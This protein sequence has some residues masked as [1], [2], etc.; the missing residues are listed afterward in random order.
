MWS[1]AYVKKSILSQEIYLK[2]RNLS[3][4]KKSFHFIFIFCISSS[5]FV[6][7]CRT[8]DTEPATKKL[9]IKTSK[10]SRKRQ[11]IVPY[12]FHSIFSTLHQLRRWFHS[13][14]K[15]NRTKQKPS[16]SNQISKSDS[17]TKQ[18]ILE[19]FFQALCPILTSNW[20]VHHPPAQNHQPSSSYYFQ[21]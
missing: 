14:Q 18:K 4:V 15:P 10:R 7:Y 20:S 5:S 16:N 19:T 17:S 11:S 13:T 9:K 12:C 2:S 21:G 1:I 8:L 3:Y 6:L